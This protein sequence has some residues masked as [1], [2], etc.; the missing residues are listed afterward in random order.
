[1]LILPE[2]KT[3]ALG[4]VLIGIIKAQLA[5]SVN[6]IHKAMTDFPIPIAIMAI[7]GTNTDTRARLDMSSVAKI[8]SDIIKR[9]NKM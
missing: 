3:I 6:G 1:M 2:E 8:E 5:A 9:S 7:M 4:G